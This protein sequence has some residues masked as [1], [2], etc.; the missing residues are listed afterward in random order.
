MRLS[1][2]MAQAR[3]SKD[4]SVRELAKKSGVTAN[5]IWA[6]E[7]GAVLPQILNVEAVCDVLGVSID[8]YIGRRP[9]D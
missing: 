9:L 4:M 5:T 7:R 1:D 2:A 6:W 3:L 8:Q